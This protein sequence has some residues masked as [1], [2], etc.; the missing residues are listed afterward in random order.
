MSERFPVVELPEKTPAPIDNKLSDALAENMGNIISL[1]KDIVDIQKMK[2]Q[3]EAVLKKME[4]DRVMLLAEADA[5][6]KRKNAD[7]MQFVSKMQ[8]ARELLKDFYN[9]KNTSGVSAEEFSTLINAIY[10]LPNSE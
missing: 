1:A 2:T 4:A 10:G 7:T 6:V 3:S 5:Y 8:F 9:Q